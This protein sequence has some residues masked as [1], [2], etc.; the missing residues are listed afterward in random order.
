VRLGTMWQGDLTTPDTWV[1]YQRA[2]GYGAV[3][4]P[5]H[6]DD[7][8][9]LESYADAAREAGLTVAEVGAWSNPL[10]PDPKAAADALAHCQHCLEI[11][12]RTGANCCVNISGSRG[13]QWDG[14]DALN[15]TEETF[16]RTVTSV[17]E[18]IDAVKPR[19]TYYSLETMPWMYPD[20]TDSYAR[21]LQAVERERF[22]VH[23]DPVNLIS[24][25]Q[26]YYAN[27]ELIRDFVAKLGPHIRSCHA[28][29]IV[30]QTRFMTHLDEAPPGRGGL[31]YPTFLR[32]LDRISPDVPLVIEHLATEEEYDQAAAAIRAVA[33]QIGVQFR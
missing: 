7:V 12:E 6:T 25:P 10:G 15:L 27:G 5:M 9:V 3:S 28:K 26:L 18:I 19:R 20:S 17:R 32:E 11:A 2:R 14:H 24:S 21:L 13:E 33:A 1:A 8:S 4:L 22:A 23:F 29:D 31:D 30:L 16:D